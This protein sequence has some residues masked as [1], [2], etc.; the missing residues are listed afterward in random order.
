MGSRCVQRGLRGSFDAVLVSRTPRPTLAFSISRRPAGSEDCGA[1]LKLVPPYEPFPRFPVLQKSYPKLIS[2]YLKTH[3]E[4]VKDTR[5]I[6]QT[7]SIAAIGVGAAIGTSLDRSRL[8]FKPSA[9]CKPIAGE[10]A[11]GGRRRRPPSKSPKPFFSD[12]KPFSVPSTVAT[13]STSLW[14]SRRSN[15]I[16]T[17]ALA[18]TVATSSTLNQL[19]RFSDPSSFFRI[20]NLIQVLIHAT[21]IDSDAI[22][23]YTGQSTS[24]DLQVLMMHT[25]CSMKCFNQKPSQNGIEVRGTWMN[26]VVD[27]QGWVPASLIAG[28][29]KVKLVL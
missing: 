5:E 12:V 7:L 15:S 16:S 29:K 1:F 18:S 23:R 10:R 25:S 22:S 26:K 6:E 19:N 8:T 28:F 20:S 24:M 17:L 21:G 4:T 13:S 9:A 11:A 27:E 3:R 2:S 14:P